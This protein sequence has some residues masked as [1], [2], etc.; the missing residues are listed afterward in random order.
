M[1]NLQDLPGYGCLKFLV[2]FPKYCAI[3]LAI[4]LLKCRYLYFLNGDKLTKVTIINMN[5]TK[6]VATV[7]SNQIYSN[8][9]T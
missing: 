1:I 3:D 2:L 5:I 4:C 7:S 9:N 8:H 6:K